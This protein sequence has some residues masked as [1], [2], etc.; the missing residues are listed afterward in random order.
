MNGKLQFVIYHKNEG[1]IK[2]RLWIGEIFQLKGR[3][4]FGKEG[5]CLSTNLFE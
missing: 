4:A 1:I 3:S 5:V 2:M